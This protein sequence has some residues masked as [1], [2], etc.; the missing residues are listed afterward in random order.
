MKRVDGE[1]ARQGRWGS[2]VLWVLIGGLVLAAVAWVG[3]EMYGEA[4][5]PPQPATEQAPSQ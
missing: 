4:I 3:V 1:D 2:R 5:D